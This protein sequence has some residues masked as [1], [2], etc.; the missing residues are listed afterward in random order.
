MVL[1][2]RASARIR[3]PHC[4]DRDRELQERRAKFLE[5]RVRQDEGDRGGRTEDDAGGLELEEPLERGR[6]W[7][8]RS[9]VRR[10]RVKQLVR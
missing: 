10:E 3:L 5:E 8:C 4:F 7:K 6:G 1:R 9:S 2:G